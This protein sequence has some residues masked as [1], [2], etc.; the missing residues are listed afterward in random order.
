M[1]GIKVKRTQENAGVCMYDARQARGEFI[2]GIEGIRLV[3]VNQ[4]EIIE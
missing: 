1:F 3:C 2:P 4:Y